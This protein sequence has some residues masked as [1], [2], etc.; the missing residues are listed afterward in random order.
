MEFVISLQISCMFLA[1][2]ILCSEPPGRS[3]QD[4]MRMAVGHVQGAAYGCII[5][6][7]TLDIQRQSEGPHFLIAYPQHN[8]HHY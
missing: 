2:C 5:G 8:P 3:L 7:L 4:R 6:D 1:L